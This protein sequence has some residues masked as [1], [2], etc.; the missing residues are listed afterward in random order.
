MKKQYRGVIFDLDG[1]L[2]NT[3]DIYTILMNRLLELYHLPTHDKQQ[4]SQFIGLGTKH[5]IT[6]ALPPEFRTSGNLESLIKEFKNLYQEHYQQHSFVYNG[7][8]KT[9][10]NLQ[11]KGVKLGILSNKLHDLTCACIRHYFPLIKFDTILGQTKRYKKP[12]PKGILNI[13][14]TMRVSTKRLIYVGD[15]EI[16]IQTAKQASIDSIG[17]TWGYRNKTMLQSSDPKYMVD[18]FE[19]L[20]QVIFPY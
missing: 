17:V 15:T 20:Y 6:Q 18:S 11:F 7:A 8:Y 3:L 5:F 10:Q 12:D 4:Y 2:L 9:L 1:T 13:S 16:D 14:K 19:E